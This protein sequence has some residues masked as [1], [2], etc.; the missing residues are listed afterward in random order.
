MI[1]LLAWMASFW[2]SIKILH[3]SRG[4]FAF[5]PLLSS[6]ALPMLGVISGFIILA[7]SLIIN[8]ELVADQ[9][10]P[11]KSLPSHVVEL[12]TDKYGKSYIHEKI[13]LECSSDTTPLGFD[14]VLYSWSYYWRPEAGK[15]K[16]HIGNSRRKD[17]SP[18][19]FYITELRKD[20]ALRPFM[21]EHYGEYLTRYHLVTPENFVIESIPEDELSAEEKKKYLASM[22]N[23]CA[24]DGTHL[25][26][27]FYEFVDHAKP[28]YVD[29]DTY[30]LYWSMDTGNTPVAA[31]EAKLI[32]HLPGGA[33]FIRVES[34][35]TDLNG[36]DLDKDIS[37]TYSEDKSHIYVTAM[38]PLAKGQSFY[39]IVKFP[40]DYIIKSKYLYRIY[41]WAS[42]RGLIPS[43]ALVTLI[44]VLF[45]SVSWYR[46]IKRK[47]KKS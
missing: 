32:F 35:V 2:H 27:I 25:Y 9:I 40:S 5:S 38:E 43:A 19:E 30:K 37:I 45:Y 31:G 34:A 6:I 8:L 26:E 47:R 16:G 4:G 36:V 3:V 24:A 18:R 39:A 7:L 23:V 33:P 29:A 22:Q 17:S 20:G 41:T 44:V 13:R 10:S 15:N 46:L 11:A 1:K 21:K 42:D 12:S 28:E 14:P